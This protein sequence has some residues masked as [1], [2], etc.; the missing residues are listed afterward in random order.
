MFQRGSGKVKKLVFSRK[1][2][3]RTVFLFL[4]ILLFEVTAYAVFVGFCLGE[5]LSVLTAEVVFAFVSVLIYCSGLRE[6]V[7]MKHKGMLLFSF[8]FIVAV[9]VSYLLGTIFAFTEEASGI[10]GSGT[11]G[12]FGS[13]IFIIAYFVLG[14][15][16][17]ELMM[18]LFVYNYVRQHS[19]IWI[20]AFMSAAAFSVLHLYPALMLVS[21]LSGIFF[22]FCYEVSGSIFQ[23]IFCHSLYNILVSSVFVQESGSTSRI[24]F[25]CSVAAYLFLVGGMAFVIHRKNSLVKSMI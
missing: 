13:G 19:G 15:V 10:S 5:T 22:C 20:A 23:A 16:C 2:S 12:T 4:F 24:L 11:D 25:I 18:R 14:P 9:A 1:L 8:V 17:E 7:P 3:V 21:F 6:T